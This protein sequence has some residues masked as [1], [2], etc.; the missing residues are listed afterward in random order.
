[1]FFNFRASEEPG[2]TGGHQTG[3]LTGDGLSGHTRSVTDMGMVTTTVRVVNGVHVHGFDLGPAGSSDF[4]F[5][6]RDTG[7][8]DGLLGS[9]ATSDDTDHSTGFTFDGLSGARGK[10]DSGFGAIFGVTDDGAVGSGGS[11]QV[12]SVSQIGFDIAHQGT[13][14]DLVHGEDI[15]D[16]ETGTLTAVN[17]LAGVHTFGADEIFCVLLIAISISKT[18]FGDGSSSSAI[19][20]D[21][22]NNTFNI[23]V[24]FSIV[25][26]SKLGLL[27]TVMAVSLENTLRVT[28]SLISNNSTH[29]SII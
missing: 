21:F 16:G 22:F 11:G 18:D 4:V 6:I 7:L 28:P 15:A 1:L 12:S 2:S 9:A 8:Q 14:G 20:D 17:V 19:M 10:S 25:K 3:F 13:F 23:T 26:V 5:V 27:H 29:F 24:S